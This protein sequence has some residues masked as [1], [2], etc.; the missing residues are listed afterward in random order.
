VLTDHRIIEIQ[1]LR[2]VDFL[3]MIVTSLVADTRVHTSSSDNIGEFLD[4]YSV[5]E[6]CTMLL[7]MHIEAEA[8]YVFSKKFIDKI[9]INNKSRD[10]Q[11]PH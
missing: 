3:A 8:I 4:Y 1:Q 2:P 9:N 11:Q 10:R 5:R 6:T 7:Q